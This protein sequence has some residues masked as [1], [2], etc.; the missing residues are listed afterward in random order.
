VKHHSTSCITSPKDITGGNYFFGEKLWILFRCLE[1]LQKFSLCVTNLWKKKDLWNP[2]QFSPLATK[3]VSLHYQVRTKPWEN[4]V[5]K[6]FICSLDSRG[7]FIF[8]FLLKLYTQIL[9]SFLCLYNKYWNKLMYN[10]NNATARP[11]I[12]LFHYNTFKFQNY[13]KGLD[14][15]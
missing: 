7:P 6:V 2:V 3:Y 11:S 10:R 14:D 13:W 9:Y 8:A 1:K 5:N 4:N 12:Y 15:I